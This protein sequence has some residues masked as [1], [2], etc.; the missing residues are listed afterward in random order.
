LTFGKVAVATV[1]ARNNKRPKRN[2][3]SCDFITFFVF[4]LSVAKGKRKRIRKQQKMEYCT[5]RTATRACG[6]ASAA[7]VARNR[8][9]FVCLFVSAYCHWP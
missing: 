5:W 6:Q 3:S 4:A 8:C 9:L 1:T 7:C 2:T